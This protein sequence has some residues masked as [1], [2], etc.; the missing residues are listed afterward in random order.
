MLG[1][2]VE[3]VEIRPVW[4]SVSG[5]TAS[6]TSDSGG[7]IRVFIDAER[8]FI[9]RWAVDGEGRGQ[10]VVTEVA[11]LEYGADIDPA[12]LTFEPPPDAREDADALTNSCS[13]TGSLGGRGFSTQLG[14]LYPSYV[15][16]GYRQIASGSEGSGSGCESVSIWSLLESEA[17]G[18][19]L[20]RQRTRP[21]GVPAALR[22]G[23]PVDVGGRDGY[24]ASEGG[25]ERLVWA[26]GE[27]VALLESDTLPFEELLRI[28][29][30]AEL[31]GA[32]S[33]GSS[34]GQPADAPHA[35][36][37]GQNEQIDVLPALVLVDPG[38]GES[39]AWVL[40]DDSSRAFALSPDG[41]A[42]IWARSEPLDEAGRLV[43]AEAS[44]FAEMEPYLTPEQRSLLRADVVRLVAA[45]VRGDDSWMAVAAEIVD[46]LGPEVPPK[47][48][49]TLHD[50]LSVL[51]SP[52]LGETRWHL[53]RTT[54]G[55]DRAIDITSPPL[56]FDPVTGAFVA[57]TEASDEGRGGPTVF[58]RE[59]RPILDLPAHGAHYTPAW[60]P[61]G[62]LAHAGFDA[63]R[64]GVP[65]TVTLY[66]I[67]ALDAPPVVILEEP[68]PAHSPFALGWS[69]DGAD[70]LAVVTAERVRVF[71]W[72]GAQLWEAAGAYQGN[73]RWS[74]LGFLHVYGVGEGG[75]PFAYLFDRDGEPLFRA[76]GFDGCDG[77][78]W[79]FDGSGIRDGRYA[80]LWTGTVQDFGD[81]RAD[82]EV[83]PFHPEPV[84]D[85][86]GTR[87]LGLVGTDDTPQILTVAPRL[88]VNLLDDPWTVDGL[89]AFTTGATGGVG[90]ACDDNAATPRDPPTVERPPYRD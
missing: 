17:G 7:V 82:D 44:L 88:Q 21:G 46:A 76:R 41:G 56:A 53:L 79:L 43:F 34:G 77:R 64:P 12:L 28:A 16:A 36:A 73:P 65:N 68:I 11:A 29:E 67:R 24:R 5:G 18:Y 80:V 15:P 60:S 2:T 84:A 35:V 19:L 45:V 40:P 54:D 61:T 58:D 51:A 81:E 62:A 86:D 57:N 83:F 78:L 55:S 52:Q 32:T 13:G 66:V 26:D 31:A 59:G 71:D 23:Q 75:I 9:L 30:S 27:A 70:R 90:L 6:D 49:D 39:T 14:F 22:V 50:R 69:R 10:S 1:R 33:A 63:R 47:L 85:D 20:L 72:D 74:Q 38:N 37:F 3:V 87:R 42:V 48:A 25:V 8:M 4:S 89:Y